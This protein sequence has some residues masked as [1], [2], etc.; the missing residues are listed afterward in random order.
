MQPEELRTADRWPRH[1]ALAQRGV[2]IGTRFA[3]TV[4]SSAS[5]VYK[6]KVVSAKD[7]DTV[8]A[9]KKTGLTRMIKNTFSAR[10][11]EAESAGMSAEQLRELLGKKREMSGIFEGDAE[12]GT[13]EAGQSAGLVNSIQSVEDV[14]KDL[15]GSYEKAVNSII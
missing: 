13:L 6:E 15:I 7:T 5:D 2:Q 4:E 12:E 11:I 9:L 1:S 8:L 10:V 14:F 3:A